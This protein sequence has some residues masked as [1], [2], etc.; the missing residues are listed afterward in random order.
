MNIEVNYISVLLAGVV[1]MVVGFLWYS[2]MVLGKPWM[3]E[4][5]FT[6]ESLKKNRP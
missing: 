3:K 1:A 2:P 6:K 5:G 4:R